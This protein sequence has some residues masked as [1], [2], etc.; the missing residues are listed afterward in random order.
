MVEFRRVDGYNVDYK[1]LVE[2]GRGG[3]GIFMPHNSSRHTVW[4]NS[5]SSEQ[6]RT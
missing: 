5:A 3:R 2:C 1:L 4:Q 6:R